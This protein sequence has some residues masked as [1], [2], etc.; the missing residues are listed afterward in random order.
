MAAG[1]AADLIDLT[2][3]ELSRW[4]RE[5]RRAARLDARRGR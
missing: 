5:I 2:V 4:L 1:Q 3:D